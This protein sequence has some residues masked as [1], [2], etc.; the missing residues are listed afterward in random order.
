MGAVL[1]CFPYFL[2][3]VISSF[4]F[5][6]TEGAPVD[7]SQIGFMTHNLRSVVFLHYFNI[8]KPY[9]IRDNEQGFGFITVTSR[10]A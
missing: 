4:L 5:K 10:F 7:P 1:I 2:P 9:N 8:R 3:S 6:I